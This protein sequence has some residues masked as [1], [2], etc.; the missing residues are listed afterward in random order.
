MSDTNVDQAADTAEFLTQVAL[1]NI[2]QAVRLRNKGKCY[3]C[4]E[5]IQETF[6]D[7][8]CRDDFEKRK[9]ISLT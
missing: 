3:N 8:D 9:N 4:D 7:A 2:P 1:S 6:C 5:P